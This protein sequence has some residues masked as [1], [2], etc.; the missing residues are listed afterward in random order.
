MVIRDTRAGGETTA[1]GKLFHVTNSRW[2]VHLGVGWAEGEPFIGHWQPICA[3]SGI[4]EAAHCASLQ[5]PFSGTKPTP[6]SNKQLFKESWNKSIR[7]KHQG[8]QQIATEAVERR[9]R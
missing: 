1:N 2:Y 6:S 9:T 8:K 5:L 4:C 7:E 3:G